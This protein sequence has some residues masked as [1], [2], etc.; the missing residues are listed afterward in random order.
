MKRRGPLTQ[1]NKSTHLHNCQRM[2]IPTRGTP[3]IGKEDAAKTWDTPTGPVRHPLN[4]PHDYTPLL[5]YVKDDGGLKRSARARFRFD[6]SCR[7]QIHLE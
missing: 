6:S 7:P 1:R 3:R 4:S 5:A 2:E